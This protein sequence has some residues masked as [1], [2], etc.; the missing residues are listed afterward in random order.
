VA[1]VYH[2]CESTTIR[3]HLTCLVIPHNQRTKMPMQLCFSHITTYIHVCWYR[4]SFLLQHTSPF[5]H[6][7][8][9]T[10]LSSEPISIAQN[11]VQRTQQ[12]QQTQQQNNNA[13]SSSLSFGSRGGGKAN[14]PNQP[15]VILLS[16]PH[17][18]SSTQWA[19]M[20]DTQVDKRH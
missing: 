17:T 19:R 16:F 7:I 12:T 4:Y 10:Y 15:S 2:F 9:C 1:L 5:I 6:S 8:C 20:A 13:L 11:T 3:V 14:R 18:P